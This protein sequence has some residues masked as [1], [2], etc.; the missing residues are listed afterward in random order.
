MEIEC[1]MAD[2]DAY[3]DRF[4]SCTKSL[5]T[6]VTHVFGIDDPCENDIIECLNMKTNSD[7]LNIMNKKVNDAIVSNIK[8]KIEI[9][10]LYH[11]SKECDDTRMELINES[12][13][14]IQMIESKRDIVTSM[15]HNISSMADDHSYMIQSID[16]AYG[17][18][19]YRRLYDRINTLKEEFDRLKI[20]EIDSM[21]RE[22]RIKRPS[23]KIESSINM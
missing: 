2:I 12:S 1:V 10:D 16:R 9:W 5:R 11:T 7:V 14:Y 4:M 3:T 6:I 17:L 18:E 20:E 19:L 21:F 15:V 13:K 22:W 8:L 23:L